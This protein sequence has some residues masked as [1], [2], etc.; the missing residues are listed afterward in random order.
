MGNKKQCFIVLDTETAPIVPS[1]EVDPHNMLVYDIG[2]IVTDWS[3]VIYE[4]HSFVV[5]ETF[6]NIDLMNSAYYANKL[7]LYYQGLLTGEWVEDSFLNI[8]KLFQ[9]ECRKYNVH[10]VWAHNAYFDC[11]TLNTTLNRYSNG[12]RGYFLP[13]KANWYDTMKYART[14]IAATKKYKRWCKLTGETSHNGSRPSLR[15]ESLYKYLTK[16]IGFVEAHTALQDAE[17]E[18]SIL[19]ACKRRGGKLTP[20]F[21][22][23]K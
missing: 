13:Y 8:W 21:N 10:K 1:S 14:T 7:P 23:K 19:R 16:N 15:A 18:L 4:R 12:F 11:T 3:G 20:L 22:K 2:W 9:D 17:I 6:R 5:R